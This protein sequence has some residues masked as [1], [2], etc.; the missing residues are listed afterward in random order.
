[1]RFNTDKCKVMNVGR[2]NSE[3]NYFNNSQVLSKTEKE[4]YIGVIIYKFHKP[5]L[6]CKEAARKANGS[7][8]QTQ[9][10]SEF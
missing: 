7:L 6:Q 3:T 2:G 1:M 10:Y 4:R 9:V 5:F 8:N